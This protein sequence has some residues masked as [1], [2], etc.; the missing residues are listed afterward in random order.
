MYEIYFITLYKYTDWPRNISMFVFSDVNFLCVFEKRK[1]II[2]SKYVPNNI[3]R[4]KEV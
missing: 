2:C 1:Y 3:E 4:K